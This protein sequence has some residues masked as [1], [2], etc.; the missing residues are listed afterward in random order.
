MFGR[1]LTKPVI[2]G[3]RIA[4]SYQLPAGEYGNLA[5]KPGIVAKRLINCIG[6]RLR[7]VEPERWESVPITWQTIFHDEDGRIISKIRI[8]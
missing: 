7:E 4:R 2:T 3:A 1:F 5:T 6:K 8:S